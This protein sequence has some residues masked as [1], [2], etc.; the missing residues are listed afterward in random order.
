MNL[1][2]TLTLKDIEF[3]IHT[4]TIKKYLSNY[5]DIVIPQTLDGIEVRTIGES[6]FYDASLIRVVLPDSVTSIQS[7][8]FSGNYQLAEVQ[9]PKR[10]ELIDYGAFSGNALTEITIPASVKTIE[11]Y[12]FHNEQS[13]PEDI[14]VTMLNPNTQVEFSAFYDEHE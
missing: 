4:G 9:L 6:A 12:A 10:L 5:K 14:A 3:D 8:A 1:P 2:Q 7:Q 11:E 13:E